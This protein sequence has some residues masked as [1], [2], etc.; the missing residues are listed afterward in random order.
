M[1]VRSLEMI[2]WDT[3]VFI[4]NSKP[5][6]EGKTHRLAPEPCSPPAGKPAYKPSSVPRAYCKH[7]KKAPLPW[8]I[9][10]RMRLWWRINLTSESPSSASTPLQSRCFQDT[11]L[12]FL[13]SCK[14]TSSTHNIR[15]IRPPKANREKSNLFSWYCRGE[16]HRRRN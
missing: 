6:D 10:K 13:P 1:L 16:L 14:Q 11:W 8:C 7:S 5:P 3:G 15:E 12:K 4:S 9:R 2:L